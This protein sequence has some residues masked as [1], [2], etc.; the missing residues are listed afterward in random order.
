M[1][2]TNHVSERLFIYVCHKSVIIIVVV[3]NVIEGWTWRWGLASIA[4]WMNLFAFIGATYYYLVLWCCT[5]SLGN[6]GRKIPCL[7]WATFARWIILPLQ[8]CIYVS[9]T[10]G[11]AVQNK[12]K[13]N[14]KNPQRFC[15]HV[16][17]LGGAQDWLAYQ[18]THQESSCLV[19]LG[20]TMPWAMTI[21]F[22]KVSPTDRL[23]IVLYKN[24]WKIW[25]PIVRNFKIDVLGGTLTIPHKN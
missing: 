7:W 3:D 23:C 24:I 10:Q 17:L 1:Y 2:F 19:A 16:C 5:P 6:L 13:C 4:S 15:W 12:P 14:I 11:L 9:W 25:T 18:C 20:I 21:W 8:I 22:V